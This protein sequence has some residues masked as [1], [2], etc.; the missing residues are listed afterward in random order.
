MNTWLSNKYANFKIRLLISNW[1]FLSCISAFEI[2]FLE[3]AHWLSPSSLF[4]VVVLFKCFSARNTIYFAFLY[5]CYFYFTEMCN[6]RKRIVLEQADFNHAESAYMNHISLIPSILFSTVFVSLSFYGSNM[7]P[8]CTTCR[9]RTRRN[10]QGNI[11]GIPVRSFP[12]S[13][14]LWQFDMCLWFD[15]IYRLHCVV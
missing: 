12:L 14:S 2:I 11:S 6:E 10:W 9:M 7:F 15:S 3:I 1:N 5:I 13:D 8:P 4:A